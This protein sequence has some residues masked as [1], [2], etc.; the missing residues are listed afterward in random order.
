IKPPYNIGQATQE[1]VLQALAGTEVVNE[2]IKK[3]VGMRNELAE[4]ISRLSPVINVYPSE[5]NFLLVKVK[6]ARKVYEHLLDLGIV[7]R[8]RSSA[9]GCSDCLRI[10]VGTKEQNDKLLDTL[11]KI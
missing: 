9:P 5:A 2:M 1:I 3:I 11:R 6:N 10:T 7:V 4:K 8:D